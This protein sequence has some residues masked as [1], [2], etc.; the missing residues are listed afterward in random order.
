[1]GFSEFELLLLLLLLL[2]LPFLGE[3]LDSPFPFLGKA[4]GFPLLGKALGFPL[5]GKALGFPFL[6]PALGFPFLGPALGFPFLGKATLFGPALGFGQ[7]RCGSRYGHHRGRWANSRRANLRSRSFSPTFRHAPE[8][9]GG[10]SKDYR[11]HESGHQ[12]GA[13]EYPVG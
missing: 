5:L 12:V 3:T 10:D 11:L 6:G 9:Q 2:L 4:L 7:L 13:S 1:M 8:G